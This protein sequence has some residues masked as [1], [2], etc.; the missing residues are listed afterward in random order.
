MIR[1][2]ARP[3]S[4]GHVHFSAAVAQDDH[5]EGDWATATLS[6]DGHKAETHVG[7]LQV[8]LLNVYIEDFMKFCGIQEHHVYQVDVA[9]PRYLGGVLSIRETSAY[10]KV[11]QVMG[12]AGE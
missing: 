3:H 1:R 4:I 5:D 11:K 2:A 8:A 9:V 10:V 12:D 7:F 6:P